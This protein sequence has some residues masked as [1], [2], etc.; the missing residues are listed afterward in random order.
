MASLWTKGGL[1]GPD[2]KR[3]FDGKVLAGDFPVAV[4]DKEYMDAIGATSQVVYLSSETLAKQKG[5]VPGNPGHPE[6]TL[7]DYSKLPDIISKASLIIQDSDVTLVFIKLDGRY[8]QTSVKATQSG[9]R[10]FTTS[11]RRV[12]DI[13]REVA[14]FKRKPGVKIIKDE[15]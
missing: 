5:L 9:K 11:F 6:L 1:T 8:Y 14:R 10:L 7:E 2:F 4:L 12:D 13:E 15:L 3:F